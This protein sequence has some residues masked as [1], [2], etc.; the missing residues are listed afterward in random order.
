M[1][2]IRSYYAALLASVSL[3]YLSLND[4]STYVQIADTYQP[5]PVNRSVY[6][7]LFR[8]F[9][10]LYKKNKGIFKRLNAT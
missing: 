5:D 6:D 8:E 10:E 2:A 9:L 7:K 4:I 3:G 1:Y